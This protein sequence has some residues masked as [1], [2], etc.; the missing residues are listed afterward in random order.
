M[1]I[2][3]RWFIAIS[4]H[5]L[6]ELSLSDILTPS[7]LQPLLSNPGLLK[8]VFPCL[9]T[10]LPSQFPPSAATVRRIIDSPP[11]QASVRQL[12]MALA[13]G[14]LQGLVIGLGLPSEAGSGVG[15]FLKAIADQA[16]KTPAP[17][18]DGDSMDTSS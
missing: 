10:D 5:P 17:P 9:P 8:T 7:T 16:K 14:M 6:P 12:D 4:F 13:T 11:F 3:L 1:S 18:A 2:S 15:P